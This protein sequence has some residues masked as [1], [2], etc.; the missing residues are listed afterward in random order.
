MA[1]TYKRDALGRFAGGGG[2]GGR[3]KA[4]SVAR[5]A[6]RLTRDNAG[7][8]TSVGGDGATARGGRL[9]TAG[10]KQ[11]AV[12]TARV[13]GGGANTIA[14]GGNGISGRVARSLAAVKRG[15]AGAASSAVKPASGV[16][17]SNKQ[18][19]RLARAERNFD[20]NKWESIRASRILSSKKSKKAWAAERKAQKSELT[21]WAA[22][23]FLRGDSDAG[24]WRGG[25][26]YHAGNRQNVAPSYSFTRVAGAFRAP[27]SRIAAP[28]SGTRMGRAIPGSGGQVRSTTKGRRLP[29]IIR[30]R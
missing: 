22:L 4:R 10:G 13:K 23:R 6:N 3:P 21:A 16:F 14:K 19:E 25:S 27:K 11:R 18:A 12:Q 30:P 24:S 8:I 26:R 20:R 15:R 29:G 9:R 1:R 5:G 2:G 7:R 17:N 28:P